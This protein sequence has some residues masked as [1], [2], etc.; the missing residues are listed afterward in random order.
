MPATPKISRTRLPLVL[1]IALAPAAWA[2]SVE[3]APAQMH[4]QGNH[5]RHGEDGTGHDE[6]NMPGLRG[7]NAT[8]EETAE[9]AALFRNFRTLSREV[10]NL[11][12]GIRTV[13]TSSD[14]D[15][16]EALVS[17]VIGMIGR[18]EAADDPRI[19][20]QSPT[21]NIFFNRGAE[22]ETEIDVTDEG[23]VVVQT[24]SDPEL[25]EALQV[26]AAEVSDMVDRGMQAVHER[27]MRRAG[28]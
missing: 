11:P 19:F 9:L 6:V 25:I 4:H 14:P 16:M 21:L 8:P 5:H 3:P 22:I 2:A 13:T 27:M 1:L 10:T 7:E 24:A 26:H 23:I 18:V 28:N 12:D 17:H 15:V 20:I